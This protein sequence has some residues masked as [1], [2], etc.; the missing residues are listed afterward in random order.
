MAKRTGVPTLLQVADK[1]CRLIARFS[2]IIQREYPASTAVH[3]AL[4]AALIAC[5]ALAVA[6]SEIREYGD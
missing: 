2:P 3:G 1:L 6:L 5:S 4:A